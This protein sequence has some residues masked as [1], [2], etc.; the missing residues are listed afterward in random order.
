MWII[1]EKEKKSVN[2][3][4]EDDEMLEDG[5][6]YGETLESQMKMNYVFRV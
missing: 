4:V 1:E 2:E 3:W 5:G 6:M